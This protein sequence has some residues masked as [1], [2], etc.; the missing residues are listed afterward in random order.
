MKKICNNNTETVWFDLSYS[1]LI[2]LWFPSS[3][4]VKGFLFRPPPRPINLFH[5]I[6]RRN[7]NS[8]MS[9]SIQRDIRGGR[10]RNLTMTHTVDT[11]YTQFPSEW[12]YSNLP[13]VVP[14]R[15]DSC[16]STV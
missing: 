3:L 4:I 8:G 13:F 5:F 7:I 16:Q 9:H 2:I 15:F 6:G 11:Q 10:K 12:K 1:Y 14:T